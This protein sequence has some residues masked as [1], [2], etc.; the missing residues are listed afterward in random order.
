VVVAGE[1]GPNQDSSF[2]TIAYDSATGARRWAGLSRH[3]RGMQEFSGSADSYTLA[4]S[5]DG[6]TL[7]VEGYD[8]GSRGQDEFA[9]AAFAAAT[10]RQL[11]TAPLRAPQIGRRAVGSPSARTGARCMPWALAAGCRRR[12]VTAWWPS[13]RD[14]SP[15][16]GQDVPGR[17]RHRGLPGCGAWAPAAVSRTAAK[18]YL[19]GYSG[20]TKHDPD[21]LTVAYRA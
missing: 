7:F 16:V 20:A 4:L 9:T 6:H 17:G 19:I 18:L 13:R 11:W 10:G 2:G 21:F 14:R 12:S 3:D 8:I 5:P 15:A 1:F